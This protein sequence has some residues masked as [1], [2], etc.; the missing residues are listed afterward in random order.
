MWCLTVNGLVC[1]GD[2]RRRRDKFRM[3]HGLV[4]RWWTLGITEVLGPCLGGLLMW[5]LTDSSSLPPR[6]PAV[7][8]SQTKGAHGYQSSEVSGVVVR[9]GPGRRLW[10]SQG[11]WH[12]FVPYHEVLTQGRQRWVDLQECLFLKQNFLLVSSPWWL[13]CWIIYLWLV[14]SM[15]LQMMKVSVI[16][17]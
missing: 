2:N 9:G 11:G 16:R 8:G 6:W 10:K 5:H 13:G 17:R 12:Q 7:M 1:R 14:C 3:S 4:G 15:S